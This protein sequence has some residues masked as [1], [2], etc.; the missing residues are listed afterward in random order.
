MATCSSSLAWTMPWTEEPGGLQS[1]GLQRVVQA[2]VTRRIRI[3]ALMLSFCPAGVGPQRNPSFQPEAA[4]ISVC[5]SAQTGCV[6]E[7]HIPRLC[8][9]FSSVWLVDGGMNE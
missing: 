7:F 5:R 2:G 1:M 9:C 4:V 3:T 6:S 8:R